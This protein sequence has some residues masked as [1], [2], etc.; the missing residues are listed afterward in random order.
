MTRDYNV[1]ESFE[2]RIVRILIAAL[3]AI[4]LTACAAPARP[5]DPSY[6]KERARCNV[7]ETFSCIERMG[8]PVRCFC[9]DKDT[10]RE[11]LNPTME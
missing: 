11:L 6:A 9:A 7:N 1:M 8:E 4:S 3:A 2:M 5:G 10:L